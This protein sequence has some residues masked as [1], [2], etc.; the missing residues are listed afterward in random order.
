MCVKDEHDDDEDEDDDDDDD[1][2]EKRRREREREWVR[3]REQNY[4]NR[5]LNLQK[6]A[7]LVCNNNKHHTHKH[8]VACEC[9]WKMREKDVGDEQ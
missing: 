6:V 8:T 3:V 2:E 4:N 1:D 5:I 9:L 7:N